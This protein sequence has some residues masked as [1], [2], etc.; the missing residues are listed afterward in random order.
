MAV[1]DSPDVKTESNGPILRIRGLRKSF[2]NHEVLKGVSLDVDEGEVLALIGV[3]GSGKSTFLRCLNLLEEPSAGTIEFEGQNVD[4]GTN[5]GWLERSR[6][7]LQ[8]R[9]SVGMVFQQFNLWP[10]RTVLQNII[11]APLVVKKAPRA[12][13]VEYAEH[14]L[15]R[16]G[17]SEKRDAYPSHLSGGQQQRVA[18]ARAL[19]MQ[20][21][22]MLFDEVTS[23][24]DPELV[25]EVLE[26]MAQ[27]AKDGMTMLCVTH[28]IGFARAVSDRTIFIDQGMIE[29]MGPSPELL[30]NPKSPRTR[31]FLERVLHDISV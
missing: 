11:E 12:E 10:H 25:G 19:A 30:S 9:I 5:G 7:M 26:L 24:L 1:I 28:E 18:I 31:Q 16:I 3:S 29:E 14:L 20:P 27:L 22:V 13:A 23:A 17:M 4:Y 6:S 2:G 8:L 15:E 21:K